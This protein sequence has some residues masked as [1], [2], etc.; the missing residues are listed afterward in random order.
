VYNAL[1]PPATN[2]APAATASASSTWSS[3]YTAAMANDN[4]FAT[5]WNSA[6][7]ATNGEWLELD[8][9]APVSFN[10]TCSGSL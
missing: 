9:P 8:W 7:G 4:S 10:R 6:T 5:R 2:L 3:G 1:S